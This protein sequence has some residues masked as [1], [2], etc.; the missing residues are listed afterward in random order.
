MKNIKLK[1]DCLVIE[2]EGNVC[3]RMRKSE[4]V[5]GAFMKPESTRTFV[6]IPLPDFKFDCDKFVKAAEE[7]LNIKSVG[8]QIAHSGTVLISCPPKNSSN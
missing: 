7:K 6:F 4:F 5:Y 2:V 8:I 1:Y 3:D